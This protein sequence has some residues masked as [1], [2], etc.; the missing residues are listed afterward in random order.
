MDKRNFF[1]RIESSFGMNSFNLK[2]I[3]QFFVA[4]PELQ[5]VSTCFAF[6]LQDSD[7]QSPCDRQNNATTQRTCRRHI[8]HV[9]TCRMY[10]NHII[11]DNFR[12]MFIVDI[13]LAMEYEID[14]SWTERNPN[15]MFAAKILQ[16][17]TSRAP[18]VL[19]QEKLK[20]QYWN[21]IPEPFE[22]KNQTQ[23]CILSSSW[24]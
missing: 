2:V 6:V 16:Q 21:P 17:C 5:N 11:S 24:L 1:G 12:W 22:A 13:K 14:V 3:S 10:I 20:A 9:R 18:N 7:K 4:W 15:L 19:Y 23:H 8:A